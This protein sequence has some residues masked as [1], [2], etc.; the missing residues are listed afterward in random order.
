MGSRVP[1]SNQGDDVLQDASAAAC[2]TCHQ[3]TAAKGH[4]CTTGWVPQ[5]FPNGRQTII[6]TK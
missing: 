4:A 2:V 6:D 5:A 1:W 3:S